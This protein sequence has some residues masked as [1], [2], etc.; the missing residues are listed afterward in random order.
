MF[1]LW[2]A[3]VYMCEQVVELGPDHKPTTDPSMLLGHTH[4]ITA[5]AFHPFV[6]G[7]LASAS[8][9]GTVRVWDLAT[10]GERQFL[11]SPSPVQS[12]HWSDAGRL[13]LTV[14]KDNVV[15]VVDVRANGGEGAVTCEFTPHDGARPPAAVFMGASSLVLTS[16]ATRVRKREVAIW[17]TRNPGVPLARKQ[18]DV[19]AAQFTPLYD[20]D[21]GF[22]VLYARGEQSMP[23]FDVGASWDGAALD[24]AV[25]AG[26]IRIT[27]CAV[28]QAGSSDTTTALVAL[29]KRVV[30][31]ERVEAL[32]LLRLG[33]SSVEPISLVVPRSVK[34]RKW[35]QDD[36]Y[37]PAFSGAAAMDPDDWYSGDADASDVFQIPRVSLQPDHLPPLSEKPP[38]EHRA[39]RSAEY[40]KAAKEAAVVEEKQASMLS[41]LVSAARDRGPSGAD[42]DFSDWSDDE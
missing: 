26:G 40:L 13:L 27:P 16:G 41:S 29:P 33:N 30:D 1:Y 22:L 20:A 5:L 6:S 37:P 39:S 17:D 12:L 3:C 10:G 15:R 38:E 32:R 34:L 9:D 24:E 7:L 23:T 11:N 19:S 8:M 18:F 31:V 42:S 35:F 14:A 2:R 21:T 36:V 4:P 28:L 25:S